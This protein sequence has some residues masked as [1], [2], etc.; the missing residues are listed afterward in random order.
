MCRVG[1][2][3]LKNTHTPTPGKRLKRGNFAEGGAQLRVGFEELRQFLEQRKM[4]GASK[5]GVLLPA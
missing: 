2:W 3:F 5:P 1:P 4:R